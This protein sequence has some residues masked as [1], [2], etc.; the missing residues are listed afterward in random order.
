MDWRRRSLRG[1]TPDKG[2]TVWRCGGLFV[3]E[4][5]DRRRRRPCGL[6]DGGHRAGRRARPRRARRRPALHEI[7]TE[8]ASGPLLLERCLPRRRKRRP[9]WSV[10]SNPNAPSVQAQPP[11]ARDDT[12]GD[13][14]HGRLHRGRRSFN[15]AG[16][17]AKARGSGEFRAPLGEGAGNV[18]QSGRDR[19]EALLQ[20]GGER[21]S[22]TERRHHRHLRNTPSAATWRLSGPPCMQ[23]ACGCRGLHGAMKRRKAG[24][25]HRIADADQRLGVQ[26]RTGI[27]SSWCRAR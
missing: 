2:L 25:A 26:R 24:P 3:A 23:K 14:G 4:A 8:C 9:P 27:R 21:P 6:V 5:R 20:E 10:R 17:A 1:P 15:P 13:L 12:I 22:A 19:R 11:S 7:E 18:A 16:P